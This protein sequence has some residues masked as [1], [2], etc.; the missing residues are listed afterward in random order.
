MVIVDSNALIHRA[1]H[2]LPPLSTKKGIQVNAVYG[3]LLVFLKALKDLQPQ[4][5]V[6]AF[7]SPAPTFRKQAYEQYK[8]KR[9]KA[10]KE[11]SRQIPL[12]KEVLEN[13]NV[14]V[15][16]KQGY[17]ADDLIGTIARCAQKQQIAPQIE[18]V[19]ITGDLDALRLVDKNTKVYTSKK[20]LKDTIIY[21]PELVKDKY[22][23][24]EPRQLTDFRALRGDPSDNI[25][26]VTGIGEKT[27]IALLKKYDNLENIYSIL[28]EKGVLEGFSESIQKK[29]KQYKEQAFF[30]RKLAEIDVNAPI[31]F[32]LKDCFHE[33]LD[34]D[35]AAKTFEE[36]GFYTLI[37][38]LS[39]NGS[40]QPRL[41]NF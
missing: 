11:L 24:L 27:A 4:Y 1:F 22:D 36:F 18:T 40:H 13:L 12:V 17:E 19:I 8:A 16:E 23:G 29:L 6:C 41:G 30:S 14:P 35:R 37:K 32:K 15:F 3:F 38:R 28:E 25:P 34:K 10:P 39:D 20:G 31:N 9:P 33:K 5:I 26:G 21:D 2:A 7:D